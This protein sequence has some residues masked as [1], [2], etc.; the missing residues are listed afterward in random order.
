MASVGGL[1]VV[2]TIQLL[3]VVA[4]FLVICSF[5]TVQVSVRVLAIA[6]VTLD[7]ISRLSLSEYSCASWAL[8]GWQ[9]DNE[10][11]TQTPPTRMDKRLRAG[12]PAITLEHVFH[13]LR[14]RVI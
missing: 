9:K 14:C 12:V 5:T 1:I 3:P 2:T 11:K 4:F 13:T 10:K 6:L 7:E 8:F